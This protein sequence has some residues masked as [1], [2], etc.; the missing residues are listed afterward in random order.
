MR[1]AAPAWNDYES[2]TFTG[3]DG[4]EHE[5]QVPI[6]TVTCARCHNAATVYGHSDDSYE[7]ACCILRDTCPKGESNFYAEP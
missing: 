5:R 1:V 7:A 4:R 2:S 3:D 6:K